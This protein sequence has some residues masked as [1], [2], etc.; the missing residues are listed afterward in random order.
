M[1]QTT[2][3]F[4]PVY[5]VLGSPESHRAALPLMEVDSWLTG[6]RGVSLP[7]TDDCEALGS[8]TAALHELLEEAREL[9]RSRQWRYLELRGGRRFVGDAPVSVT[10]YG[11]EINLEGGEEAILGRVESSVRRAIR[12]AEKNQLVIEISNSVESVREFYGL[13]C[14]T[15]QRHGM[16]PQPLVFFENIQQKLLSADK[17]MVTLARHGGKAVAGALYLMQ[18]THAIY[19]YGASDE[20]HQELRGNNLV[21][22]SAMRWLAVRGYK[23]LHLGRTSLENEGLRRFKLGWGGVESKVEYF[24]W[25]FAAGRFVTDKD[26][27]TGWHNRVFRVMPRSVARW[28]GGVLYRHWA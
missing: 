13:L 11:H 27:A 20:S 22:W 18:G 6:R 14:L 19:K 26:E 28:A 17:G 8:E 21:M 23:T 12:K 16:P 4:R 25:D 9:G 2:Y 7:F 10:F 5:L 3:G 15:R 24:K 1:L